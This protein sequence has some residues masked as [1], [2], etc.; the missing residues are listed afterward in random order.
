MRLCAGQAALAFLL[1][2]F[3][4][5]LTR[6]KTTTQFKR[7]FRPEPPDPPELRIKLEAPVSSL[8]QQ[9]PSGSD[10]EAGA[11]SAGALE[12]VQSERG[13]KERGQ[14]LEARRQSWLAS[15]IQEG[16][17]IYLACQVLAN[18]R[19]AKPILW[20][21]NGRPLGSA[22]GVG[23][24]AEQQQQVSPADSEAAKSIPSFV[25]TNQSTLVLRKVARHQSGA[26]TCEASNLHG[27]SS[28]GALELRVRHAP[29]CSSNQM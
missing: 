9:P 23:S 22:G 25:I 28:S 29:V 15:N 13:E 26:Y 11:E 4:I 10:L 14:D 19:P 1:F 17:D 18:P 27:T 5:D 20:R 24:S 6:A 8:Q 16:N 7:H 3:R 12:R 21:F 2:R